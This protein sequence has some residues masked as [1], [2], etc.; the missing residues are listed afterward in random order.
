MTII[1]KFK[2]K[3]YHISLCD[4]YET[5]NKNSKRKL[6]DRNYIHKE[7]VPNRWMDQQKMIRMDGKTVQKQQKCDEILTYRVITKGEKMK[8]EQRGQHIHLNERI[9]M[10]KGQGQRTEEGKC[11]NTT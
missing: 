6:G 2:I 4:L 3:S 7:N 8:V 11:K 5:G 1:H 9:N 10:G